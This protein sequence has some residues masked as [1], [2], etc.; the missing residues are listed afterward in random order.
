MAFLTSFL[1]RRFLPLLSRTFTTAARAAGKP[2]PTAVPWWPLSN[3]QSFSTSH[4][5]LDNAPIHI[6][7][8]KLT[9]KYKLVYTCT[10][11]QE[12]STKHISKKAYHDGVV[13]VKCPGCENHHIIADNLNWFSDLE[14]KKN[15]EEI[16]AEKGEHVTRVNDADSPD[17]E[18]LSNEELRKLA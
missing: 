9:P 15:I 7:L 2:Q 14:G 12:R 6:N 16:M 18:I 3:H 1:S 4:R 13:L 8:A 5:S 10:V 11:C 17:I